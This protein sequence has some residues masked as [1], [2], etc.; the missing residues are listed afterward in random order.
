MKYRIILILFCYS[1]FNCQ[2]N[3]IYT[4]IDFHFEKKIEV[5]KYTNERGTSILNN[6][7]ALHSASP[8]LNKKP[9]WLIERNPAE[10]SFRKTP[11]QPTIHDIEPPYL[12]IKKAESDKFWVIKNSDTLV[13]HLEKY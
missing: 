10:Y 6:K 11:F 7:Y 3:D 8:L 9:D 4:S 1:C 5:K 13:F 2:R 12:F